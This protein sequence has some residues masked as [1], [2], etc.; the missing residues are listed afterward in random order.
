MTCEPSLFGL[1][2]FGLIAT[3]VGFLFGIAARFAH[4]IEV[5]SDEEPI[6]DGSTLHRFPERWS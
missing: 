3:T 4:R 5:A 2:A 1:I 6:G